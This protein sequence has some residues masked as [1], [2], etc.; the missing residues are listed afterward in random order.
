[1]QAFLGHSGISTT[2]IYTHVVNRGVDSILG[3]TEGRE[4]NV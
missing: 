3:P 4:S 1:M 2:E